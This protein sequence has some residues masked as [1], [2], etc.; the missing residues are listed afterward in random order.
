MN[1]KAGAGIAAAIAVIVAGT[2]GTSYYMGGKLQQSFTE[3]LDKWNEHGVKI[4]VT[5]YDRG[6]FSSTAKTVWTLDSGDE[7]VQ[8][9]AEHKI[10]HG[11]LPLGHAAEIH[12]SFNLPEDADPAL[13]TALN[14]RSP[15]EVDTKVGWGR[16]SSN[17]M[18]SPA[19]SSKI[20][21]SE[22]NWGGMKLVWDM[23]ADM[24]AAKGTG[25]FAGLQFKD[26]EGSVTLDKADMR[27][28]MK[29]PAG[30]QFWTGPFAM[31]IAK[32][33][34]TKQEEEGKSSASHFEGITMDSDTI[35]KGEVVE[36]TLKTGIKTAKLEDKQADDLVLDMAFNNVDANWINQVVEM[37]KRKNPLL[38]ASGEAGDDEDA[39]DQQ[40]GDLREKMLKSLT[41]A[42]ARQP[43]IELKR[44]SMR[45][46]DGVSEFAAAIQYLG[47]GEKMG[48]LLQ[49]LKV[50]LKADM[51]KP[52]MENMM[53]SRRRSSLL[54]VF[55]GESEYKP[56]DIEE[57]A[58]AQTQASL[59][60]LKEQGIFEDKDGKMRTEI[61]Y[62]K[63][64]FQVNGKPLD[65]MGTSTLMG[66]MT[67]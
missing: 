39:D 48:N 7:P 60:M 33:A 37:S 11:P 1:K 18:T 63:G 57:A 21:D 45:T 19:V 2:L 55:E 4:Q 46:P 9:T 14:G 64:E 40:S 31:T 51:P 20:K 17:V 56:E 67:E 5:S 42:L 22:M 25:S 29:Q 12:T 24:K 50:S 34:A 65:A 10:S 30:Q 32:I 43:V 36:M 23:P 52:F 54:A 8:F 66:T 13:K 16:S 53:L 61:V 41:Q 6:A 47:D 15:L 27:F 44:L 59:D 38:G 26:E 58:K 62:A 49:D 35:L 28:D 3:G